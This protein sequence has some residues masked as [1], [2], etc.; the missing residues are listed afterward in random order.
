MNNKEFVAELS[1]RLGYSQKD[2][3]ALL[4]ALVSEV[5]GQ[6]EEDRIVSIQ[7]FGNFE[8]RKKLERVV[9]SPATQQRM[10]VPPR[11]VVAFKPSTQL[12]DKFNVEA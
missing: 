7:D 4:S 2:S 3:S 9:I 12:K 1:R 5:S 10:L 6:L 8:V 11:L